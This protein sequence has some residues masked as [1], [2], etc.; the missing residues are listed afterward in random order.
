MSTEEKIR[1]FTLENYLFTDDQSELKNDD[2]FLDQGILDS[3]GILEIIFFIEDEFKIKIKDEEMIPDNLDSVD[4]I[5]GFIQRK[6][7]E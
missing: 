4:K 7:N 3:T 6:E 2:S 5:V 1:A